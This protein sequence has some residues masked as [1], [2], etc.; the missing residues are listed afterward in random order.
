MKGLINLLH[1]PV[2]KI[3]PYHDKSGNYHQ[4]CTD[5]GKDKNGGVPPVLKDHVN[6]DGDYRESAVAE[7]VVVNYPVSAVKSADGIVVGVQ[8]SRTDVRGKL[9]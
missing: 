1:A 8:F 6:R 7:F 4:N 3:S 5:G 9:I 2:A